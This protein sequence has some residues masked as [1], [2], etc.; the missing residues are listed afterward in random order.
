METR[1][2]HVRTIPLRCAPS[3]APCPTCGKP[4]KR[5]DVLRRQVR[6]IAYKQVVYL[7]ITYGE[8]RARCDC[9]TTFRTTPP[10]VQPRALYDNKV[11]D[12]VLD[13]IL[14]DGMSIEQVIR[15]MHRDFLLD[16][17]D[18]FVYDCLHQRVRQLDLSDH[19][20]WVL[21]L[22]R[23]TLCVDELHLGRYTLLLAT[24]PL[25]DLP[26]AFA[27]VD[28]NDQD[29]MRRFLQNLKT[30]G[31]EPEVVVTDGS[32][33]YPALLAELWP[34]AR[35]QLC[36]FHVLKDLH[37]EVLDA[38]RRM[39]RQLARRGNRGRK[40]KR[41]RR[42][43]ARASRRGLTPKEKAAFIFKRRY[44]I[45]KRRERMTA[46]ER[47]DLEKM[48][49]YLPELKALRDF[50]DRLA[51][52]F[53]EG[54]S[55]A[56]AWGRHAALTN[57]RRF[58]AVPELAAAMERLQAEKFA[59]M[60]A[61]LRSPA[62]HRVRTNNH[63]ERVNRKLRYQEKVRYKWRKRRTIVRFVVLLLDR[64]W[65]Q[66]RRSRSRW[67]EEVPPQPRDRS[68]PKGKPVKQVA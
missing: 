37:K 15:S 60:I 43:K 40:P 11:R 57:N 31:V 45:V 39:R 23:G 51:L 8:Y 34:E 50:V 46:Q 5:K 65:E 48:L 10:G 35:H 21:G 30:W 61:F 18:G 3:Q 41:G 13:R 54:Q 27:L 29:H 36:V 4:G 14:E 20:R 56:L 62:Y 47:L 38:L 16:L 22:F 19:R 28:S 24:D 42:P 58:L 63:V 55:E 25:Q 7:D 59:K 67:R 64:Y 2:P 66:E 32:G 68:S 49:S 9:C 6:T 33:L 52:L 53:E 26:V 44:L 12:A 17:S 1:R